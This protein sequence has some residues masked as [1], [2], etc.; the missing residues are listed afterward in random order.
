M[1]KYKKMTS[2]KTSHIIP[3]E[4][5]RHFACVP[6]SSKSVEARR[7][8][9]NTLSLIEFGFSDHSQ[10]LL[11]ISRLQLANRA[12]VT[13]LI[14]ITETSR[15]LSLPTNP[16]KIGL[17]FA[18]LHLHFDSDIHNCLMRQFES[19]DL[20]R[21][22]QRLSGSFCLHRRAR[23]VTNIKRAGHAR[24]DGTVLAFRCSKWH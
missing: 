1:I 22:I 6:L 8:V 23:L 21:R 16:K 9:I 13:D 24:P 18:T 11:T 4:I 5:A 20:Y 17:T 10:Q 15:Y 3:L 14:S 7:D 2:T 19:P 12:V